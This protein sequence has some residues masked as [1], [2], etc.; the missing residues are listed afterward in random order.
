MDNVSATRA[1]VITQPNFKGEDNKSEKESSL[2][3]ILKDVAVWG[4]G[5]GIAGVGIDYFE[6]KKSMKPENIANTIKD[7]ESSIAN[8]ANDPKTI[9]NAKKALKYVNDRKI[10][11][12][13]LLKTAVI[14]G[15]VLGALPTLVLD[16]LFAGGKAAYDKSKNKD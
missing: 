8:T 14:W 5:T 9:E 11:G 4:V 7:L 16:C 1:A 2:T 6:Q 15:G 10:N 13:K 3:Q 12:S